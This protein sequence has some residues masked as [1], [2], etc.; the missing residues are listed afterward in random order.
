MDNG[1]KKFT[2]HGA[3]SPFADAKDR[4]A[5]YRRVFAEGEGSK[6]LQDILSTSGF[7]KP[8]VPSSAKPDNAAQAM[9]DH[10]KKYVC[11]EILNLLSIK[12]KEAQWTDEL[13]NYNDNPLTFEE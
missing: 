9:F 11:Y 7:F 5:A 4:Q 13:A 1:L 3:K 8:Y 10:G 6:V 12:L 2:A